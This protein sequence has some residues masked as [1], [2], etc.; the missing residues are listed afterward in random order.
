MKWIELSFWDTYMEKI[1]EGKETPF[2]GELGTG[3]WWRKR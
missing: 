3:A 2:G 1:R